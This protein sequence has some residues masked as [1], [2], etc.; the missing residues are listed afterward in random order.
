MSFYEK[1]LTHFLILGVLLFCL[2]QLF[3]PTPLPIIYLISSKS[4][5][6]TVFKSSQII[7]TRETIEMF[8]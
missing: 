3:F 8:F 2:K 6:E 5:V 7:V 1:P 4:L